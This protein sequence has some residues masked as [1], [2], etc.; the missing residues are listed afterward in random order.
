MERLLNDGLKICG[1]DGGGIT[2]IFTSWKDLV[3]TFTSVSDPDGN[4]AQDRWW[5][6]VGS[7]DVEQFLTVKTNKYL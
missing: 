1:Q 5:E 7:W 6:I 4:R 2:Y 3:G